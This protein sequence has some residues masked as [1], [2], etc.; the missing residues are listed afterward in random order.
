MGNANDADEKEIE[1][2]NPSI[3]EEVFGT[4]EADERKT[5]MKCINLLEE[6][7]NTF[8]EYDD[9]IL[10]NDQEEQKTS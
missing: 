10:F 2:R 8:A 4:A 6:E 7:A 5:A 1:E 9:F 3:A